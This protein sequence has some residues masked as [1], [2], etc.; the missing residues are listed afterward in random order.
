MSIT[1]L[2]FIFCFLLLVIIY[3]IVPKRIQWTILLVASLLFYFFNCPIG[4]IY[5]FITASS[6][7]L[8][9]LIISKNQINEKKWLK[10]HVKDISREEKNNYKHINQHI[11]LRILVLTLILN[12]GLLCIFKY[13]NFALEQIHSLAKIISWK[14]SDLPTHLKI[15]MPLGISFYTFQ[16]TGYLID[17]YWGNIKAENNYFKVLLFVSFFPQITQGPISDFEQLSSEL[18]KEHKITYEH[19]ARGWQRVIWGLLK[20]MVL[21]DMLYPYVQDVFANYSMYS[22]LTVLLGAFA[23]SIQIYADFSG[24]MDIMCGLCEILDIKLAE[25][26]NRPY[27]SKSIAEYWRRWHITLGDWFKKY[28]YYP[29]AVAQWNQKFSHSL[30]EKFGRKIGS[31]LPASIALVVVWLCTGLWHGASWAY[32]AWGG[33]NGLFIIFSL[34]MEPTYEKMRIFLHEK[35]Y[36]GLWKWFRVI[37]TFLLV[38]FIKVLPEVGNLSDGIGLWRQVFTNHTIPHRFSSL[39]PFVKNKMDLGVIIIMTLLLI[40][41]SVLQ[42]HHKIR[43]LFNRLPYLVRIFALV[44]ATLIILCWGV[45]ANNNGGGFM[46]VNF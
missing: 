2:P 6:I 9:G 19:Y 45:A 18:F 15:L 12:F 11:R 17:V 30:G 40:F 7:Y 38:T 31:V 10:E 29:V 35:Q 26:F 34:W 46:Y 21:A 32:I 20:K 42:R 27:F 3:Y 5:I 24:Y 14:I 33:V 23:Y 13:T 1:S 39:L 22:G 16:S 37:R 43:D 36:P 8:S 41:S 28:I 25:N 44:L 4:I